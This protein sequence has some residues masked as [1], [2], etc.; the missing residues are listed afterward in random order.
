M[1][2]P[3]L[4]ILLFLVISI[5][6]ITRKMPTLLALPVLAIG[7][8]LIAGVPLLNPIKDGDNGILKH[9]LEAGSIRLASAYVAVIFGSWLGQI[10]NK[11]NIAETIV[12][13]AA[14][15]GG[16]RP[17]LI[18]ILL[19]AAVA[20]LFTT[21]GGLGAVIMIGSIVIPIMISVGVS[22]MIAVCM[23]LFGLG[24]GLLFN[25]SN[26]SFYLNVIKVPMESIKLFAI[27]LAVLT[28]L[29]GLIFA[30]VEF[31]KNGI[32]FACSAPALNN[33]SGEIKLENKKAPI[34][35]LLTPIIPIVLVMFFKWPI[36][37]AFL[38]GILYALITTQRKF[39]K[40][41][42][43]LTK[44]GF[45]GVADAAPAVILM[46]GIGMLL[47]ALMHPIV[48]EKMKPFITAVVPTSSLGYILFFS[49]LAPLAL[50]RGPLN[51]FGL[52][53]GIAGLIVSFNI[54]PAATV[55]SAFLAVERVQAI[56]DP[57][58]T[59]NVWLSN[60]AGVDVNQVLAKL[61]PYVWVLA[62][63]GV[64]VGRFLWL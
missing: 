18:T 19:T 59:H 12:K 9:I 49:L 39:N 51:L 50:Y 64:V 22:S 43:M 56:A 54:L 53:S 17:F 20:I 60:Y 15:L 45:D 16:D 52:G 38:V 23:F 25:I 2:V 11:T 55:M 6:M 46:I 26:W 21:I 28:A 61:L 14:E 7:V 29:T 30:I 63:A 34:I 32:K 5:L 57:T 31:K 44:T 58:N 33:K 8:A 13:Y 35:S 36:V 1:I 41:I 42:N 40:A 47:N 62:A 37:P 27:I 10:M 3:I 24:I 4:I 48:A